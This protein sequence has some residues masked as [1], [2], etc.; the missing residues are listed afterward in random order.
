MELA[1][2]SATVS[3]ESGSKG[4]RGS[5]LWCEL[6]DDSAGKVEDVSEGSALSSSPSEFIGTGAA[7]DSVD[8]SVGEHESEEVELLDPEVLVE[9]PD[10]EFEVSPCEAKSSHDPVEP[11][12]KDDLEPS[13]QHSTHG[14]LEG[15]SDLRE[16][17]REPS[18]DVAEPVLEFV[19]V[20]LHFVEELHGT[21]HKFTT[22]SDDLSSH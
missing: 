4:D 16:V 14:G 17:T 7:L 19:S 10:D 18:N 20:N 1:D 6:L 13:S 12:S 8:E 21:S 5:N 3:Q 11:S 15:F 22:K 9:H 2:D